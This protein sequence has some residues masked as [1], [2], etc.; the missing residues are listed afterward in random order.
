MGNFMWKGVS[1]PR[2]HSFVYAFV[3]NRAVKHR[4]YG[5]GSRIPSFPPYTPST[6]M[7]GT[8]EF[9]IQRIPSFPPY[10]PSTGMVHL[11]SNK[12]SNCGLK[13]G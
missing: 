13:K 7:E 9:S 4:N 12:K 3:F 11:L 2:G 5:T 1:L 10:T 8:K 6:G